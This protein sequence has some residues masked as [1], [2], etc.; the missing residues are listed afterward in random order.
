MVDF[1]LT[2]EQQQLRDLAHS[3][4]EKEMR[5]VTAHHDE[6][7]EF[8]KEVLQK[9]WSL[10]LMNVHIPEACGGMELGSLDG[11]IIGE[12]LMWGCTGIGTAI[13]ANSL[14]Q[15]PV[16]V[17]GTEAQKKKYLGQNDG[18]VLVCIICGYRTQCWE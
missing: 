2:T 7:G 14:A 6:T 9:A 10:G 4:A 17:A 8:P 1:R 16:V 13:E 15:A 12:E 3:F 5:P 18:R 11:C